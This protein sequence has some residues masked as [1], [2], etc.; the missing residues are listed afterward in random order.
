ME[1]ILHETGKQAKATA[2]NHL[3][4]ANRASH[5]PRVLAKERARRVME[6]PK[7][8]PNPKMPKV[9]ARVKLQKLVCLVLKN[10]NQRQIRNLRN[11][12]RVGWHEGWEQTCDTSASPLS[13]GGF[14]LGAVR[15][16]KR[17]EWV[18]MNLGAGV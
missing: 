12:H 9:R 14:D 11:L 5:G 10:R 6:N 18:K 8:N 16:P 17:F 7:E 2:G 3:A 13:R 1:H 4:E 15:S